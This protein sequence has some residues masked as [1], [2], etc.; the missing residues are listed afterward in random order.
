MGSADH[1][2]VPGGRVLDHDRR[3]GLSVASALHRLLL[4]RGSR[5]DMVS[6]Y[7]FAPMADRFAL[8]WDLPGAG[9]GGGGHAPA[10]GHF[11]SAVHDFGEPR[12]S[13]TR[14]IQPGL[15]V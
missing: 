3:R 14:R 1:V 4:V 2:A 12:V 13:A 9:M 6:G 10:D 11:L 15:A 7:G 8:A 5:R